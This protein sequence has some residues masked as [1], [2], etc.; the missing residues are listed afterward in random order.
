MTTP[1]NLTPGCEDL[2]LWLRPP[3]GL[4]WFPRSTFLSPLAPRPDPQGWAVPALYLRPPRGSPGTCFPSQLE[5]CADPPAQDSGGPESP[6]H[7]HSPLAKALVTSMVS[8]RKHVVQGGLCPV[9]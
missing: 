4:L 7:Q 6:K 1:S 2:C 8:G 3:H 9:R 5:S